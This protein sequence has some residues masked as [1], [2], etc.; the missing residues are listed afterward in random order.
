MENVLLLGGLFA[1]ISAIGL[2]GWIIFAAIIIGVTVSVDRESSGGAFFIFLIGALG[3]YIIGGGTPP[4]LWHAITHAD[5][6]GLLGF[7]V[8]FSLVGVVWAV[9]KWFFFLVAV[10]DELK[11]FRAQYSITDA[12]TGKQMTEAKSFI[13]N[14]VDHFGYQN[15]L[16]P[17]V[18]DNKGRIMFWM[19]WWP[20]SM[21]WTLINEPVKKFFTFIYNRISGALQSMSDRMFKGMV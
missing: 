21:P 18:R 5:Y 4:A 20:F 13:Q 3:L 10:R 6:G 7:I 14:R 8:L 1:A 15:D 16:P 2:I 19:V 9:V 11:I 12:L 17:R